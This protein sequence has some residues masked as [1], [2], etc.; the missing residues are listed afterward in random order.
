MDRKKYGDLH[1]ELLK[2]RLYESVVSSFFTS[3]SVPQ[4]GDGILHD[5]LT[6]FVTIGNV[7]GSKF[8]KPHPVL[9]ISPRKLHKT[10]KDLSG[11]YCFQDALEDIPEERTDFGDM[12]GSCPDHKNEILKYFCETCDEPICLDCTMV[13]HRKHRFFYLRDVYHKQPHNVGTLLT[14]GRSQIE[15]TRK[16]LNDVKTMLTNLR[17][18]KEE[19]ERAIQE[20]AQKMVKAL[21]HQT[22]H[23]LVDLHRAYENKEVTLRK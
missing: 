1:T 8:F 9:Q 14:Q 5:Y 11:I 23:L 15:S 19:S 6:D 3:N 22:E 20:H 10:S 13:D 2:K 21:E 16:C 4:V 7:H 12:L 18:D 17:Q